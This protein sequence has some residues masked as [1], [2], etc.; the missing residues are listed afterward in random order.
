MLASCHKE[1]V[2]QKRNEKFK[3]DHDVRKSFGRTKRQKKIILFYRSTN[4]L[5]AML[6]YGMVRISELI[7]FRII[8]FM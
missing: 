2:E 3:N 8:V 4:K 5:Y 7:C 1:L 6:C